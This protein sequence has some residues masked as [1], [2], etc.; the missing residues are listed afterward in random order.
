MGFLNKLIIINHCW[1]YELNSLNQWIGK[2]TSHWNIGIDTRVTRL[3]TL[4][5]LGV[6]RFNDWN[7]STD[8]T[9]NNETQLLWILLS[10]VTFYPAG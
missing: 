5:F 4:Y 10:D 9:I 6:H 3:I 1:K 7:K 8:H 2:V